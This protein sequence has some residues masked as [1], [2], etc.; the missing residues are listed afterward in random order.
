MMKIH[1][2]DKLSQEDFDEVDR[3]LLIIDGLNTY[4]KEFKVSYSSVDEQHLP[5]WI[6]QSTT[7]LPITVVDNEIVKEGSYLTDLEFEE[8]TGISFK[9]E[10]E[11][12]HT[13]H[14]CCGEECHCGK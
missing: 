1:I 8:I 10:D 13:N 12:V 6:R 5:E 4:S 9:I 14:N 11:S 7:H 2:Y 3:L